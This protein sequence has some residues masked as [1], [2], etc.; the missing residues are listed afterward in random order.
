MYILSVQASTVAVKSKLQSDGLS[1]PK[2]H[3]R[4]ANFVVENFDENGVLEM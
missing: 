3:N 1:G 2:R 4:L